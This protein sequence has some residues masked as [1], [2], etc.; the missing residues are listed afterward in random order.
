MKKLFIKT[1]YAAVLI[2]TMSCVDD[3]TSLNVNPKSYQ[4]GTIP[5]GP[6]FSNATKNLADQMLDGFNFKIWAQQFAETTYFTTSNYTLTDPGNGFWTALYTNVL[7]DYKESKSILLAN[8]S[9][10]EGVDNNKLAI[11]EIMEIYTYS[12]LVNTFGNIPY[13]GALD[14]SLKSEALDADNTT[15]AYDDA[16]AIYDDLFVRLDAAIGMLDPDA[17]NGGV[18]GFGEADIIY[19][20]DIQGWVMFANALKLRMAMTIA[21]SN[22]T[23]AKSIVESIDPADLYQ[24]NDDNT[25]LKYLAV[26]PNTNPVW[27]WL[28]QSGREDYVASNTMMDLMQAPA[29]DDPRIPFYYTEDNAG[30]YSGGTYGTSNSYVTFSKAGDKITSQTFPGILMDYVEVEFLLAEAGA[31]GF[32]ISGTVQEHYENGILASID[33]WG[34]DEDDALDYLADP[35]VAFATA[36]GANDIQKVARQKYIAMFNRGHE[37]WVDYRRLDYP[38]FNVPADPGGP[39]PFRYTYPNAEQ[40]SNGPNYTEAAAAMGEDLLDTKLFWDVE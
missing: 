3:L 7:L 33:Y 40:T 37:A 38:I 39:F 11:I 25:S 19:N 15:P 12:T 28:V 5:E 18:I 34:A 23:K 22:P 1:V 17:D 8:P 21:D 36:I 31:R 13:S 29:M 27:V 9:L 35:D 2:I 6:F 30:E 10:Y 26:T 20:D 16:E 24:S 14:A 4:S 32:S